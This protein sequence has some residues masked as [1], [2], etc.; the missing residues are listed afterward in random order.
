MNIDKNNNLNN[1]LSGFFFLFILLTPIFRYY[2]LGNTG[3][4]MEN[5]ISIGSLALGILLYINSSNS[6][7][8]SYIRKSRRFF[9]AFGI[10]SICVTA[11]YELFTEI[12]I[13][14]SYATYSS[15][16]FVITTINIV[17]LYTIISGRYDV[18]NLFRI[19]SAIIW[20]L[21]CLLAFQWI[22]YLLGKTM[23]FKIPLMEFSE[24]W[25]SLESKNFGMSPFPR[26]LFSER[27]HFAQYVL[28]YVAICLY[29]DKIVMKNRIG[30]AIIASIAII[31]TISGNGII[32]LLIE[33]LL[34]FIV[35]SGLKSKKKI[36]VSIM[37]ITAIFIAYLI[38]LSIDSFSSMFNMLFTSESNHASKADYRIY[39]GLDLYN[40]LPILQKIFGIGNSH[41]YLFA[42]INGITSKYD[43]SWSIYEYF[44]ALFELIIYYGII[45][46][47]FCYKHLRELIQAKINVTT[48]L[49]IMMLSLWL[50][51]EMLFRNYHIFYMLLI[52]GSYIYEKGAIPNENRNTNI[53]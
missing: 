23:S 30:K 32:V 37:G 21:I 7:E 15:N 40:Q 44:S 8:C 4:G 51:T 12:N 33:W 34:Y 52:I 36:M 41:M 16:V 43:V 49:I 29:S 27:S 42:S 24:S 19:Y 13:H 50:S 14:N 38:M 26:A 20:L 28:P 35:L 31:T 1:M 25:S 53:S 3:I 48:G 11:F 46:F 2:D 9:A 5:L 47:F 10:W 6:L 17:L 39:R 18:S 22:L 45:G